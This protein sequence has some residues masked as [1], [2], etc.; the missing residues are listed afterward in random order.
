LS[1]L[2]A[3]VADAAPKRNQTYGLLI[4]CTLVPLFLTPLALACHWLVAAR[5]SSFSARVSESLTSH[6]WRCLL[7]GVVNG[8]AL[9]L[10]ANI[11]GR[12]SAAGGALLLTVFAGLAMLGS[13]GAVRAL[14]DRV[15]RRLEGG[16]PSTLRAL[17]IGCFVLVYGSAVPLFGWLFGL[18]WLLLGL[19][20]CSLQALRRDG[21]A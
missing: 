6:P 11:V 9:L 7:L 20:A 12:R 19:G 3:T 17:A 4:S 13:H 1:V 8:S 2:G 18:Y 14:G 10:L 15:S 21:A 5:W 16:E